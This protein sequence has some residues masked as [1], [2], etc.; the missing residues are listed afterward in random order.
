MK[1]GHK[2]SGLNT[3]GL[4]PTGLAPP[5]LNQTCQGPF[6]IRLINN[7]NPSTMETEM[8]VH[9]RNRYNILLGSGPNLFL[10]LEQVSSSYGSSIL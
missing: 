5:Q 4:K 6:L 1:A 3:Q 2:P 10:E 9:A 7:N 8:V